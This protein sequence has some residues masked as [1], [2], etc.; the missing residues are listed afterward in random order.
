MVT[1]DTFRFQIL[2]FR[3]WM[4]DFGYQIL[5]VRFKNLDFRFKLK[6]KGFET[7]APA[8]ACII[9]LLKT[10][11]CLS[12]PGGLLCIFKSLKNLV[13]SP[14]FAQEVATI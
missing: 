11:L 7:S 13:L 5:D 4:S 12:I 10:L 9:L 14:S 1:L 6:L 3:F 8:P 2:N